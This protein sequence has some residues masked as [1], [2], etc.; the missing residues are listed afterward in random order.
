MT[1]QNDLDDIDKIIAEL[2]PRAVAKEVLYVSSS[3]LRSPNLDGMPTGQ[4]NEPPLPTVDS[5]ERHVRH[6]HRRYK[7]EIAGARSLL[8]RALV[9]Q[10]ELLERM[11]DEHGTPTD[12][13]RI[14]AAGDDETCSNCHVVVLPIIGGRCRACYE[15]HR[16]H[17]SERPRDL[18][19]QKV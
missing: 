15:Y 1:S 19:E 4:N 11:H 5:D 13:A 17:Q 7:D 10:H 12:E 2:D 9:R 16:R 3:R 18:W 8:A 14:L 6:E